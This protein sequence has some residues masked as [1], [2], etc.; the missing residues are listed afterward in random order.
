VTAKRRLVLLRQKVESAACVGNA[1]GMGT[2]KGTAKRFHKKG[3][4]KKGTAK[5]GTA[6]KNKKK[7]KQNNKYLGC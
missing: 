7:Q 2:K 5:K 6:K 1:R 4:A 3:P